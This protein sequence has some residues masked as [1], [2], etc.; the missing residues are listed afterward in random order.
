MGFKNEGDFQNKCRICGRL[1]KRVTD[2][3]QPQ[4]P[5]ESKTNK[6]LAQLIYKCLHLQ[7]FSKKCNQTQKKLSQYLENQQK[8]SNNNIN[9]SPSSITETTDEIIN[10]DTSLETKELLAIAEKKYAISEENISQSESKEVVS[11][12]K[13]K[14]K[15][16]TKIIKK[17]VS[18][19]NKDNSF[20]C[21]LETKEDEISILGQNEQQPKTCLKKKSRSTK[22]KKITQLHQC[23]ICEKKFKTQGKLKL[24]IAGHLIVQEFQC[25]KCDKKF[26]SKFSLRS[27]LETHSPTRNYCCHLCGNLFHTL[28][29]LCNHIKLHS[30]ET[31]RFT[32]PL[33]GKQFRQSGHLEQH[34]RIHTGER[35]HQCPQC[36]HRFTTRCQLSRHIQGVHQLIKKHKCGTCGKEFLYGTN[37]KAHLLRHA[38]Q[39]NNKCNECGKTFITTNALF[40]HQR[41][42]TG[43]RPFQCDICGKK[44]ADCSNRKRHMLRHWQQPVIPKGRKSGPRPKLARINVS[45]GEKNE[46]IIQSTANSQDANKLFDHLVQVLPENVNSITQIQQQ[47][48]DNSNEVIQISGEIVQIG[49]C[50]RIELGNSS[51]VYTSKIAHDNSNIYLNLSESVPQVISMPSEK[52]GILIEPLAQDITQ[53]VES[54]NL[55]KQC[56]IIEI[57]N[58]NLLTSDQRTS[59]YIIQSDDNANKIVT[60]EGKL[61]GLQN[62]D[63][64]LNKPKTYDN[65]RTFLESSE[66]VETITN[67]K[68]YENEHMEYATLIADDG[69]GNEVAQSFQE[70]F[71][72]SRG[73]NTELNLSTAHIT[74]QNFIDKNKQNS[75]SSSL[76]DT[77]MASKKEN[78]DN[79]YFTS[80]NEMPDKIKQYS[81]QPIHSISDKLIE[82]IP[83]ESSNENAYSKL[84]NVS[85][86]GNNLVLLNSDTEVPLH[87]F[88]VIH[89]NKTAL[90]CSSD[91]FIHEVGIIQ[92]LENQGTILPPTSKKV[93]SDKQTTTFAGV[94]LVDDPSR[95]N[96]NN[97][98]KCADSD[99]NVPIKENSS[100]DLALLTDC[101]NEISL[102]TAIILNDS[103]V[104]EGSSVD[105]LGTEN[106][107]ITAAI[108]MDDVEILVGLSIFKPT[109]TI[110]S[111]V[112]IKIN[113]NRLKLPYFSL[114]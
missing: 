43:D 16:R 59:A 26:R 10:I 7:N 33:C 91:N 19:E 37:Y 68:N 72:L 11:K 14:E 95:K 56:K 49:N 32:C 89:N 21:N 8:P 28:S 87:N 23:H 69:N 30:E 106:S 20:S 38:G 9:F 105:E 47:S 5:T 29:G 82:I 61:S 73:A 17:T 85:L 1:G 50:N 114:L 76:L 83:T 71:P 41:S 74:I 12:R 24:H 4:L 60:E 111:S 52:A 92:I 36:I 57:D 93:Q 54:V 108:D 113:D 109:P 46:I 99:M 110:N 102:S 31:K 86:V 63:V 66:V 78:I 112:L 42:H 3:F 44:F 100:V 58:R 22:V 94:K 64:Q 35:P 62:K 96:S 81:L 39:R 79:S 2:I 97:S 15:R 90:I 80:E 103:E 104:K 25:D 67:G 84:Q 51:N 45:S 75:E 107:I 6:K 27:H 98:V 48:A 70:I 65:L 34:Q 101:E 13:V 18:D 55:D 77:H 40:R 88:N 53:L